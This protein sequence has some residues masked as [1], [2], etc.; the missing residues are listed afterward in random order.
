MRF[1]IHWLAVTFVIWKPRHGGRVALMKAVG[2]RKKSTKLRKGFIGIRFSPTE[3]PE[4][5]H[6]RF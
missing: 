2:T 6:G 5:K 4:E 1:G 3:V